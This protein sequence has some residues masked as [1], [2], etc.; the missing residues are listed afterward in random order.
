MSSTAFR[1]AI[2][3]G[4]KITARRNH[5]Y[6]VSYYNPQGMDATVYVPNPD[7]K[8]LNNTPGYILIQTKIEGTQLTFSFYGTNDGRTINIDGPRIIEK[9]PD[10]SLKA[11]FTQN[12]ITKDGTEIINDIFNSSYDSPYRYP[13]PGGP[14]LTVKPANWSADEWKAYKKA[15]KIAQQ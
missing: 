5:A 1:A 14:I 11:T 12:V 2:Y 6:P 7:M 10:G 9:Q 13:H 15:A 8:F 3:S 4:L